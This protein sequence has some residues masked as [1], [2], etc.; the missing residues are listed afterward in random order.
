M[1]SNNNHDFSVLVMIFLCWSWFLCWSFS[2]LV[3]LVRK[4][5]IIIR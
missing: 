1:L 4:I 5:M 2:V 3:M